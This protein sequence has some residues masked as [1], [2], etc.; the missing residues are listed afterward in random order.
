MCGRFFLGLFFGSAGSAGH[1]KVQKLP[2]TIEE[3]KVLNTCQL[4]SASIYIPLPIKDWP[5]LN[6]DGK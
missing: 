1:L 2:Y 3:K 5:L 6:V 4:P